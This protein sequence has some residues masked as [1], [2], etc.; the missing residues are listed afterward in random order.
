MTDTSMDGARG[1]RQSKCNRLFKDRKGELSSRTPLDVMAVVFKFPESGS[2]LEMNLDELP[3][4]KELPDG[5]TRAAV[6]FGVNTSVGNTFGAIKGDPIAA[7]AAAEDRWGTL[8]DGDWAAEREGGMRIGDLVEA[9]KRAKT[10]AGHPFDEAGFRKSLESGEKDR[11]V[12][13]N[14]PAVKA[15]LEALRLEKIQARV[16]AA[17]AAAATAK[18]EGLAD[19]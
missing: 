3:G 19:I 7:E 14:I 16:K 4:F 17:Q 10:K 12:V 11:N 8:K 2:T 6:A 13:A 18:G 15:E 5:V 9:V 1:S